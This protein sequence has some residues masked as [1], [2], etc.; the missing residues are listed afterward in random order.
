MFSSPI[1]LFFALST[2]IP[3]YYYHDY[4]SCF[5]M[6]L[7]LLHCLFPVTWALP[8]QLDGRGLQRKY[9]AFFIVWIA[10]ERAWRFALFDLIFSCASE[11]ALLTFGWW[12]SMVESDEV[13][14]LCYHM[15]CFAFGMLLLSVV[16]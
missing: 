12:G 1:L 14:C 9:H 15:V 10:S 4:S 7:V 8:S 6:F 16:M 5:F 3:T 13:G 2:P 11:P